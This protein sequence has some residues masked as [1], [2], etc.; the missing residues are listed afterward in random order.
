MD[1][2]PGGLDGAETMEVAEEIETSNAEVE[3]KRKRT[4][5]LS[6]IF[7]LFCSAVELAQVGHGRG[8]QE[9]GATGVMLSC[10]PLQVWP[11]DVYYYCYSAG[12][13]T[14][15]NAILTYGISTILSLRAID[16]F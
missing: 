4:T 1:R 16:Q 9:G 10:F 6:L 14:G 7:T 5:F 3:G 15:A 11:L 12:L 13:P 2:S 8:E